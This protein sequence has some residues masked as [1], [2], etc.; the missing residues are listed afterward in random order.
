MRVELGEHAADGVFRQAL[1]ADGIDVEVLD[2]D[3]GYLQLAQRRIGTEVY[4]HLCIG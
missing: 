1:A 3:G 2:G 4:P